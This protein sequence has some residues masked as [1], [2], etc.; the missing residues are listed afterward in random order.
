MSVLDAFEKRSKVFA[1][2]G[3]QL[4]GGEGKGKRERK[5][6]RKRERERSGESIRVTPRDIKGTAALT[7]RQACPGQPGQRGAGR[8]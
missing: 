7:H 5:T 2:C 4:A 3:S 1:L 6:K 8:E